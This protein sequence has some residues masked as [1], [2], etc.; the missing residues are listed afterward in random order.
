MATFVFKR[1]LDPNHLWAEFVVHDRARYTFVVPRSRIIPHLLCEIDA[2]NRGI[3]DPNEIVD[4]CAERNSLFA[5]PLMRH[6]AHLW[7][8]KKNLRAMDEEE[9]RK[10]YR[11]PSTIDFFCLRKC[12]LERGDVDECVRR[13]S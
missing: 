7:L 6:F 13:C 2:R 1:W 9:R 10:A 12:I 3:T 4:Y 11:F 5:I 8:K